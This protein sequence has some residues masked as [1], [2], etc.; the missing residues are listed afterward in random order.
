MAACKDPDLCLKRWAA[1]LGSLRPHRC[2]L[3]QCMKCCALMLPDCTFS[4]L[5][6]DVDGAASQPADLPRPAQSIPDRNLCRQRVHFCSTGSL[7]Y[8]S[9]DHLSCSRDP[10]LTVRGLCAAQAWAQ[11]ARS[12]TWL[13]LRYTPALCRNRTGCSIALG[14][15][16]D[17]PGSS[18]QC[19]L[20]LAGPPILQNHYTP[21]MLCLIAVVKLICISITVV[22]G[23]RGGFIFP[24]FFSGTA[25]GLAISTVPNI[26]FISDL[27]PV[28]LAMTMA[29]GQWLPSVASTLG[30]F[31][32]VVSGS[33][34][35]PTMAAYRCQW[36]ALLRCLRCCLGGCRQEHC[37]LLHCVHEGCCSTAIWWSMAHAVCSCTAWQVVCQHCR[38]CRASL[39]YARQPLR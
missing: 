33:R 36:A 9:T 5:W 19:A 38:P 23:F 25:L 37:C 7:P 24:L 29:A 39:C 32:L 12:W 18:R 16:H 20:T 35:P 17:V 28:M 14:T 11:T 6:P 2:G 27:P 30:C 21:H 10:W 1:R 34:K 26:P 8:G 15:L 3:S 4:R 13:K 31:F 22:S